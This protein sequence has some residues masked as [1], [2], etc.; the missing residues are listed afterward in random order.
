VSHALNPHTQPQAPQAQAPAGRPAEL[1]RIAIWV[2]PE[3][4][5]S[6][7]VPFV[8]QAAHAWGLQ[9]DVLPLDEATLAR[10]TAPVPHVVWVHSAAPLAPLASALLRWRQAQPVAVVFEGPLPQGEAW[11]I[12][13]GAGD[14]LMT[15]SAELWR[16]L[17][18]RSGNAVVGDEAAEPALFDMW[19]SAKSQLWPQVPGAEGRKAPSACLRQLRSANQVKKGTAESGLQWLDTP[20]ASGWLSPDLDLREPWHRSPEAS[21]RAQVAATALAL[22]KGFVAADAI[23]LGLTLDA[24]GERAPLPQLSW[25]NVATFSAFVSP[26]GAMLA[27]PGLPPGPSLYAIVDSAERLAACAEHGAH[28]VQLRSKLSQHPNLQE[29]AKLREAVSACIRAAHAE[30]ASLFINDHR[31]VALELGASGLHLGQED[32]LAL[33]E[34][35]RAGLRQPRK[36]AEGGRLLAVDWAARG[37]VDVN[38]LQLLRLGISSHSVWEL[39]RARSLAP[40]YIACGPVWAT[41]TKDMPWLPQGLHNLRWWVAHAGCPV[42]AIGGILEAEHIA[43]TAAC[44]A[45]AVCVVRGLGDDPAHTLPAMQTALVQGHQSLRPPVPALPLPS[46]LSGY[47]VPDVRV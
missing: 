2:G 34:L 5:V 27:A 15:S 24:D 17:A 26:D 19:R 3:T 42:V 11:A 20:H 16:W 35:Q 7:R 43:Q 9:V 29:R 44:G 8:H 21:W 23:T 46:L 36:P 39:A 14:V 31:Q 22:A 38:Q 4:D 33:T 41:T 1:P 32:L 10:D 13:L 18:G 30:H 6:R 25:S 28:I 45:A 12:L 37:E 47:G 40:S